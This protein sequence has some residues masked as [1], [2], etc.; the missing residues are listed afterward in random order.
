MGVIRFAAEIHR[1][2]AREQLFLFAVAVLGR[3]N[4]DYRAVRSDADGSE[5]ASS[6]NG[7]YGS[8]ANTDRFQQTRREVRSVGWLRRELRSVTS[9]VCYS[10]PISHL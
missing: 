2:G 5:M 8:G 10:L 7:E 9:D 4:S 1:I 3:M 6:V